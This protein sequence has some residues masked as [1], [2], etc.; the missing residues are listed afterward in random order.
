VRYALIMKKPRNT[1]L[2]ESAAVLAIACI[3]YAAQDPKLGYDD[4][5]I[6]P[7]SSWH[8]HDGMRPQPSIVAVPQ[9]GAPSDAIVLFDG[10]NMDEWDKSWKIVDDYMEVNGKGSITT[11]RSFGDCQLHLE[12]ATPVE[13]KGAGQGR[14]NSGI[15]FMGA[16][17]IQIL[18]SFENQTY[19]DGQCGSLYGQCPPLVNV[20]REPG[21][22]QSYDIVFKAPQYD[23]EELKRAASATVFQNGVCVHAE[24]E[25]IGL[26]RHRDVAQYTGTKTTGPIGL[27][28]HGNPMRFRNIW[29]R[30]LGSY[31]S[32]D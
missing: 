27:Q 22:W 6:I 14:G 17:E 32:A 18:D 12:F 11:K 25:F 1:V 20:S 16:F 13:V 2:A 26:T 15:H 30:P 28:D 7:D 29:V 8:V 21:E 24:R 5:P 4:T 23:G 9:G 10:S 31:D 19:P 3:L